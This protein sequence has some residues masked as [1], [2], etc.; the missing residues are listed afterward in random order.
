MF[1]A[2][3]DLLGKTPGQGALAGMTRPELWQLLTHH[4]RR[5]EHRAAQM[6]IQF[7]TGGKGT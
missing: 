4:E 5:E 3:V 7:F 6:L 1:R 2:C